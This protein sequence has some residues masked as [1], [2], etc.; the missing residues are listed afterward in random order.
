MARLV[1]DL[2]DV[3]RITRG[4]HPA[5]AA[6]ASTW[7][8]SCARLRGLPPACW[9]RRDVSLEL[10]PPPRPLWLTGDPTRLAQVVGNLLSNAAKFTD[11]GG[12]VTVGAGRGR[13]RPGGDPV[14]PRHR[15]RHGPET[16]RRAV[17]AVRPGRP[18]RWSARAAA[19][20]WGWRWSRG[21]SSC[22]AA[23]VA[24]AQRRAGR[25]RA[26]RDRAAPRPRA[27]AGRRPDA[28][29]SPAAH[30]RCACW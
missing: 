21:W 15:H 16:A 8:A 18:L 7:P 17:R 14:G 13:R 19:S 6:S 24:R 23:Q 27:A 4:K 26:V 20:G 22:T 30:G 5:A 29:A 11:A 1:D 9:P 3:A 12:R 28:A 2:L 10:R 25:G